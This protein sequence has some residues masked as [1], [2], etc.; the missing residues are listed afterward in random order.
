MSVSIWIL[1]LLT[2]RL[3]AKTA[4]PSGPLPFK[5]PEL[6]C[7][8]MSELIMASEAMFQSCTLIS[9]TLVRVRVL[10]GST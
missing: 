8:A 4:R 1:V 5:F 6:M 7:L 10:P 3:M 9:P 2:I